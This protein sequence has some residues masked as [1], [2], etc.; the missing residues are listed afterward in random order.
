MAG[1][2]RYETSAKVA[3]FIVGTENV[4]KVYCAAGSNFLDALSAGPLAA[5][6]GSPILLVDESST[7]AQGWLGKRKGYI[8]DLYIAGGSSAVSD[9][10]TN[11]LKAAAEK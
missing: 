1:D 2:T 4:S 10:L 8:S 11:S 9:S 5:Q 3:D 6:S 7:A